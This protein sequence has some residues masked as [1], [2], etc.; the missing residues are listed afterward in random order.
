MFYIENLLK[1]IKQTCFWHNKGTIA[2]KLCFINTS[3]KQYNRDVALWRL[4]HDP[5]LHEV[6][7]FFSFGIIL[8][9]I[10]NYN[11]DDCV[12]KFWYFLSDS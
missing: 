11:W 9:A 6:N 3:L 5:S 10:T 12:W 2:I 1:I 8:K 7:L 4:E